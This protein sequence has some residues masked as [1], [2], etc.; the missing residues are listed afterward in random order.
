MG[1]KRSWILG[2]ALLSAVAIAGTGLAGCHRPPFFCGSGF[3]GEEFPKN[4]LEKID[5]EVAALN[6]T[7]IQQARYQ[8]IRGRLETELIEVGNQR[9]IF[10]E[11][12][13]AE[14]NRETPDVN[15]LSAIVKSHVDNFPIR[16]GM[17]I[18]DFMAFYDVLDENQKAIITTQLKKK[19]EKFEAF[20][21]LMA[22]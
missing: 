13:K 9:K 21:S 14:M 7:E 6:L 10:Y 15:V 16:A 5:S 20:R 1:K 11:K 2:L 22:S 12:V 18:D 3:Q 17:F 8:E 4:V 19:F